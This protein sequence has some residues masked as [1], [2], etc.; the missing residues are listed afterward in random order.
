V[1]E[2]AVPGNW[3]RAALHAFRIGKLAQKCANQAARRVDGD[4]IAA[5][6]AYETGK[7]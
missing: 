6:P 4:D 5:N 3:H 2:E 7:R 1:V